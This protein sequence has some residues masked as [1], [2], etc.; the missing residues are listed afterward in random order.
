LSRESNRP[1]W[2]LHLAN[3]EKAND[4]VKELH[5]RIENHF[6]HYGG[7]GLSMLGF[8]PARDFDPAQQSFGFDSIAKIHTRQALLTQLPDRIRD[9]WPGGIAFDDLFKSLTNE[10][11]ATREMIR[12]VATQL[13]RDGDLVKRGGAGQERRA[14]TAVLDH[15]TL[16][17]PRQ[18]RLFPKL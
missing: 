17:Q 11:P 7:A 18:V 13:C 3:S 16:E 15:D 1:Y 4:V 6:S 8:D 9:K 14:S 5:W 2:F 10:T 12:E